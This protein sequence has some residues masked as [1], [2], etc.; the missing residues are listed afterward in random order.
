MRNLTTQVYF[1]KYSITTMTVRRI[2]VK[3][4]D[5]SENDSAKSATSI[6]SRVVAG[7]RPWYCNRT[8]NPHRGELSSVLWYMMSCYL[9]SP[10]VLAT[11]NG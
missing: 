6:I 9:S 4:V 7:V 5:H 11:S 1:E 8:I 2:W 10:S 3:E